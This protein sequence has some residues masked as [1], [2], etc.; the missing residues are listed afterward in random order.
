MAR[1]DG[2]IVIAVPAEQVFD[3]VAD[4]RNEPRYNP[5]IAR[6]EKTSPVPARPRHPVHRSAQ[7]NGYRRRHD[8]GDHGLRPAPP[9]GDR[10]PVVLPGHRRDPH[11]C[12]RKRCP[13]PGCRAVCRSSQGRR[14]RSLQAELPVVSFAAN[15]AGSGGWSDPV[16]NEE[17]NAAVQLRSR[18]SFTVNLRTIVDGPGGFGLFCGRLRVAI[19]AVIRY[20][21][22]GAF[23]AAGARG[24]ARP[25]QCLTRTGRGAM[26]D[27][28]VGQGA[29]IA[30]ESV[31][32]EPP[33]PGDRRDG[34][35][36]GDSAGRVARA[37]VHRWFVAG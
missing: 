30:V 37:R 35:R 12:A 24:R 26:T 28:L 3:M 9:P 4:E 7:G 19:L 36:R 6:A 21:L 2:E 25:A 34:Q 33:C 17:L 20:H 11:L 16:R 5:R 14:T 29:G 13:S 1:I 10:D 22:R 32:V 8:R 18:H 15:T 23:A 31:Q 27:A